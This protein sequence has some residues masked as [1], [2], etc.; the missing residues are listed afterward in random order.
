VDIIVDPEF[1][2][3]IPPLSEQELRQLECSLLDDGTLSP[4]AVWAPHN[5]LL[6]GHHRLRLCRQHGIPFTTTSLDFDSRDAARLWIIGHQLG[7]RNLPLEQAAYFRG[8]QYRTTE[9]QQGARTDLALPQAPVENGQEDPRDT[10]KTTSRH[11][12]TK[13]TRD[14]AKR[15]AKKYRVSPRTIK[16]DA[17]FAEA[18]D[19][20]ADILGNEFRSEV[21]AGTSGLSKKDIVTLAKTPRE[22]LAEAAHDRDSLLALAQALRAREQKPA[23]SAPA[24]EEHP[25]AFVPC[26]AQECRDAL[27]NILGGCGQEGETLD[28]L[29]GQLEQIAAI[30]RE[31]LDE[32]A[33]GAEPEAASEAPLN[34]DGDRL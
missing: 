7:R 28:Y 1:E 16:R 5:I 21:L 9:K 32:K 20:L 3:L 13:S 31:A 25:P 26:D 6:D 18:L 30:A 27:V 8:E 14:A 29:R 15:L 34:T 10:G 12:D 4:L 24:A 23:P 17:R 22:Q 19:V 2:R 11:G 33:E